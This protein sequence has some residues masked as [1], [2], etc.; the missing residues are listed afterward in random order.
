MDGSLTINFTKRLKIFFTWSIISAVIVVAFKISKFDIFSLITGFSHSISL[1]REMFPPNFSRFDKILLVTFETIAIGF[2]GTV[3]GILLS[4]PLGLLSANNI[5]QG[6]PYL[7][8]K[9]LINFFRAVPDIMFALIFVTAFGLGPIPGILALSLAT[10]GLLGKFYAEAI[11]SIDK[12]PVEALESTGS[13][14][15]GIIRHAIMPQVFPLFMG[16]NFY[17]LDHNIRI[18]MVLG[19]VGAGGLGVEL[20]TQMRSFNY[21]KVSAILIVVILII[22][23][24]D[25]ASAKMSKNIIDGNFM[26]KQNKF[27][28]LM[29]IGIIILVS[30]ISFF[31]I[32]FNLSEIF[33]G[34]PRILEFLRDLFPPKI[35]EIE[36][37]LYLI[38]ETVSMGITGT[39]LAI[40]LSIPLGI[41]AA[42]NITHYRVINI[43]SRETSN[44]F[45]AMPEL[46]FALL[47][48]AAV[49]LG[50]FA[51]VLAIA[52]HTT[53]FLGKFYCE[54]IENIDKKPLEAIDSTGAKYIQKIR[55]AVL[56]QI[57]P[58]FNSYNLYLL[59][60]N[61]RA[62][63]VMGVV[64]AGGIGFELIMS[65]RVFDY[66]RALTIILLI[67]I[68]IL[69]IDKISSWLRKKIT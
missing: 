2:W 26:S 25:R 31:F 3:F 67:L 45:R 23:L 43:F 18:A 33:N 30:L 32:P 57:I 34:I 52:L 53:G 22:T 24:I 21:Q 13:H 56:P 15:L 19:L 62:S 49:G 29:L 42:R 65:M 61:I 12:K 50:P 38:I 11:E 17:L 44:F 59:D 5:S 20:F 46:M 35:S 58:L 27:I 8:S 40:I 41:L 37:Y 28:N 60:R 48:V 66:Q 64:G 51:G 9:G 14:K 1:I 47:F 36:R 69:I 4:L 7:V 55:H 6:L 68:T 16:Y 39:I 54:S 63:T 10:V